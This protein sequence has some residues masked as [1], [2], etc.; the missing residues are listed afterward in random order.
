MSGAKLDG[1]FGRGCGLGIAS[2]LEMRERVN[3][4]VVIGKDITGAQT[5][6]AFDA[7]ERLAGAPAKS[8]N[9]AKQDMRIGE[10]WTCLHGRGECGD[11]AL[12]VSEAQADKALPQEGPGFM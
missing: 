12:I 6:A 7:V 10:I 9:G 3:E 4:L 8:V 2:S 5:R 11:A 1:T